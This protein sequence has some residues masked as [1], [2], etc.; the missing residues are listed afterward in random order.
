MPTK[1]FRDPVHGDLEFDVESLVALIDTPEF[2]RLRGV[3]QLGTAYLVYP[4]AQHTRFEHSLGT[5][6]LA[7]VLLRHL[8]TRR[9]VRV[10]P[11][12]RRAVHAAALLHDL[13]HIP[14][15]HT[16]EDERRILERH[17]KPERMRRAVSSGQ[18]GERLAALGLDE[19]V[20]AILT[21]RTA[22]PFL[23]QVVSAAI[24]ADLLDYLARDAYF[25]GLGVRYDDRIFRQFDVVGEQ[26]VIDAQK[27]GALREDVISEVINLLRL[28]YFL[29]ERVYY[30][31]AKTASG[32]MISR[33]VELALAEGLDAARLHGMRDDQL[34]AL[35]RGDYPEHPA[36]TELLGCLER[37]A[38]YKRC[39][40]LTHRVGDDRVADLCARYHFDAGQR[41][42]AERHL[43]SKLRLR[44]GD[45]IVYCPEADMA[46]KEARV[47]VR[48]DRGQ[49][50]LLSEMAIPEV[51]ALLDKHR[52][53]WKFTVFVHP[54]H[55]ERFERISA[56]CEAYFTAENHLPDYESGQ[57]YLQ[58]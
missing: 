5:C 12:E 26:L 49:P 50:R 4:G 55:A 24:G 53:L 22:R 17:D 52:A 23:H 48:V 19:L 9:G 32:A 54:R 46:L 10:D 27:G 13:G 56:A 31:H 41:E 8:E 2:Q 7:H 33:A 37:H 21:E 1:L 14:F 16:L 20:L 6:W 29:S 30:H 45:L 3:K 40:M 18:L 25:T 15:G 51:D 42:R 38:L 36:L 11:L 44:A 58:F 47:P 35:L 34:L 39:F 57:L 43:E 28:R